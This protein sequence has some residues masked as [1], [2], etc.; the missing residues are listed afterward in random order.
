MSVDISG[1]GVSVTLIASNTFPIALQLTQFADDA[2]P[3]DITSTDIA[4]AAM[5]LNGDL[6]AWSTAN[7]IP[8][9]LNLIP[10]SD[11]DRNM[12]ILA[13]RNRP[14][15]GRSSAR[16]EIQMIIVYPDGIPVTYT[17]G[18]MISAPAGRSIASAGRLK[19]NAYVFN[20]ES[21]I[22]I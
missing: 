8:I 5:G 7:P 3:I 14:S 1:T 9:T 4:N 17:G 13:E 21:K 19:T 11:D 10:N 18:R 22:G 16:D 12:T 15:R 6:V 20:F 2:D